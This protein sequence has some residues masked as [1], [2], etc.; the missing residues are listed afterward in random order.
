MNADYDLLVIGAGPAGYVAGIRAAQL[1]LKAGVIEKDKPGGVC[2][3]MGC[4][5]SKALIHQ[6]EL[7][8]SLPALEALGVKA[9]VSGFN[10]EK[11]FSASRKAAD[12]LSKGVDYLLKKNKVD[13]IPGKAVLE[14]PGRVRLA[15]GRELKGKNVLIATG[16][17]PRELTGFAFDEERILSS[18]GA[19]MLKE[20]PA[21]ICILGGGAIGVEFAHIMN[22]F[23]VEVHLVEMLERL[24]P[25]MDEEAVDVLASSFKK[26]GIRTYLSTRALSWQPASAGKKSAKL[27]VLLEGPKGEQRLEA[28]KLLVVTGRVPNTADIGLEKAGIATERGFIPVGEYYQTRV[29]GIFAAGDVLDTPM[30]AH[31]ASREAEIAVEFMAGGKPPGK[32]DPMGIPA[33]VY[34]EPQIAGF[35]YSERQAREA[36]LK[37]RKA[38]FPYRGAGKAVAVQS[39]EG[40]VKIL[41]DEST[42]ELLGA[43]VAG[44]EATEIIHELL[45]ARS[46]EL[47]ATDLA[48]TVHAHPT[49]S[50]AVSEAA[51][52]VEG[53]AIHI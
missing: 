48:A 1:G 25:G 3:N 37:F 27:S 50:E 7:F 13:L 40:L 19:L 29:P 10:Y 49:F 22:G 46:S 14:G 32:L 11:V 21:S 16:S 43:T 6:A 45:L 53:R 15:E 38:V 39:V 2:L 20:L 9:D 18:G 51:R 30:L 23:G 4:I 41:S 8:R 35:G 12:R 52:L 42:G 33:A 17:A 36:G 44:S 31:A 24:L 28:D 26:R 34:C 5:P 47:L